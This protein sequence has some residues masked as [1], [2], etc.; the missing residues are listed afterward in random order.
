MVLWE[1]RCHGA[2][3]EEAYVMVLVLWRIDAMVLWEN[4]MSWCLG[5]RGVMCFGRRGVMALWEK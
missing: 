3:G 2:L 4:H 1:K 5:R